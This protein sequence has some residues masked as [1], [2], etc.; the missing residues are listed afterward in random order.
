MKSGLTDVGNKTLMQ[1]VKLT[2]LTEA[3]RPISTDTS[4][5]AACGQK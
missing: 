5:I 3:Q 1:G 4:E 2:M